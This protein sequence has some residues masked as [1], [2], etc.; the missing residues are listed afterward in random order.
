VYDAPVLKGGG[1]PEWPEDFPNLSSARNATVLVGAVFNSHDDVRSVASALLAKEFAVPIRHQQ[2][3]SVGGS[4]PEGLQT[5]A[6]IATS[7][8]ALA[9][10]GRAHECE[11][12]AELFKILYSN[13]IVQRNGTLSIDTDS[14]QIVATIPTTPTVYDEE[15][16]AIDELLNAGPEIDRTASGVEAPAAVAASPS[17]G[18]AAT[19]TSTPERRF[20]ELLIHLIQTQF[21]DCQT[22]LA[23]AS[24]ASAPHGLLLTL[25]HTWKAFTAGRHGAVGDAVAWNE[26]LS[27]TVDLTLKIGTFALT[28]LIYDAD[29][30]STTGGCSGDGSFGKT[31]DAL[32]VAVSTYSPGPVK[33]APDGGSQQ[34]SAV[35]DAHGQE[36]TRS[37]VLAMVWRTLKE[38]SL[39]L[40][41]VFDTSILPGEECSSNSKTTPP[42]T[43]AE[44]RLAVEMIER[45]G[46]WM[47]RVL[48]S[49]RHRG[50]IE[51]CAV[52][53]GALCKR[54]SKSKSDVLQKIPVQWLD[55]CIVS[56][57]STEA[58]I[59]ITRRGAGLP[60]VLH[61]I[62]TNDRNP[63]T[64][65]HAF[66]ALLEIANKQTVSSSWD[67]TMDLPAVRALNALNILFRDAGLGDAS[68]PF[69][70]DA[71]ITAIN[72]FAASEWAISNTCMMLFGTLAQKMLG[73]KRVKDDRSHIN[74]ITA[75]EF[76]ARY[77]SLRGFIS[78]RL[79]AIVT[80]RR[81]S[82]AAPQDQQ[83]EGK[84]PHGKLVDPELYP[85]LTL[86]ARLQSNAEAEPEQ[87]AELSR[88][89]ELLSELTSNCIFAIRNLAARA[90]GP[91]FALSECGRAG[92]IWLGTIPALADPSNHISAGL[93][94]GQNDLHGAL[95]AA[96]GFVAAWLNAPEESRAADVSVRAVVDAVGKV[97]WLLDPNLNKCAL[98]AA[99]YANICNTL[100]SSTYQPTVAV[101][102]AFSDR[103]L[104]SRMPLDPTHVCLKRAGVTNDIPL[105][106]P[107]LLPVHTVNCVQTLKAQLATVLRVQGVATSAG[108]FNPDHHAVGD[109]WRQ[110]AIAEMQWRINV[111]KSGGDEDAAWMDASARLLVMSQLIATNNAD[112][113]S[114][115]YSLLIQSATSTG[116]VS[117][118]GVLPVDANVEGACA[119]FRELT[120]ASS[121]DGC[122]TLAVEALVALGNSGAP[123]QFPITNVSGKITLSASQLW[124]CLA[125]V[126]AASDDD[127]LEEACMV[128]VGLLLPAATAESTSAVG[129]DNSGAGNGVHVR[130]W[131]ELLAD[132]GDY[133][134]A[135]SMRLA[136]AESMLVGCTAVFNGDASDVGLVTHVK[137]RVELLA[138]LARA[139]QD[140]DDEVRT[141][142]SRAASV[143]C[144]RAGDSVTGAEGAESDAL[145]P[146]A[147]QSTYA[148]E[149]CYGLIQSQLQLQINAD[150]VL[151]G[152]TRIADAWKRL[153]QLATNGPGNTDTS[154]PL[155]DVGGNGSGEE[156]VL[157]VKEDS[158]TFVE[159]LCV[160][161]LLT[162]AM[163]FFTVA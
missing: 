26:L 23:S 154:N 115:A 14:D 78:S 36:N 81:S 97:S 101:R 112:V 146:P 71:A 120:E 88:F 37:F 106:C 160:L 66:A 80:N 135:S 40:G 58:A 138:L 41:S 74:L 150:A 43:D 128:G 89:V 130:R 113:R 124:N 99:A 153:L 51:T 145:P 25:R 151:F 86:L 16:A 70:A 159:P 24:R 10:S 45:I 91:L 67:E 109:W 72:G 127:R 129:T 64:V 116:T 148:L 75:R 83:D 63:S 34:G 77:P 4:D 87:A 73:T 104:H 62:V 140:E 53:L 121:E 144:C 161:V 33:S 8:R 60:Y 21:D 100:L 98:T 17:I 69:M 122:K 19:E 5:A 82:E 68:Q 56:M 20:V 13:F 55:V 149:Q 85:L 105:G 29:G 9:T 107:L 143:L 28:T 61:A 93:A 18:G 103:N 76:F 102:C 95:L 59:S 35:A 131:I 65:E 110:S 111:L 118:S 92:V 126:A 156:D 30:D 119:C 12:G 163:L 39:F 48:L 137:I 15:L 31:D 139:L 152:P 125:D 44:T 162:S 158:N 46:A 96:H 84:Q 52:G 132:A 133:E 123:L 117:N 42:A 147:W 94:I 32:D 141:V 22:D 1:W 90:L 2:V 47:H 155:L 157:F 114:H 108:L 7:A 6:F 142:A 79:E 134:S 38:A 57:A 136:A 27:K 11:V 49:C 54:L 50:V 3:E